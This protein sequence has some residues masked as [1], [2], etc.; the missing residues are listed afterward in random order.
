MKTIIKKAKLRSFILKNMYIFAASL[1]LAGCE[2]EAPLSDRSVVDLG[3]VKRE[4]TELD[5]WILE[6]FTLPYGIEVK[7]RWDRNVAQNG[8]YT[9]PPE[10]AN[11]KSV[12]NAIKTLWI[13]LYTSPEIGG[14]KFLLGKNPIKIYMYGGK[15]LDGNGMEL[16]DNP[17]ATSNEMFLY[18]VNEF[19]PRNEDKVFV[20]MRSVHH[21]FARHLME[22]FPYDRKKF[23]TISRNRY[24]DSTKPIAGAVG[25]MQGRRAFG[26]A[27]YANRNGFFTFHSL[28]SAEKD[29][30]E[31]ISA[32][33]THAPK[34]IL[35]ALIEAKTPYNAGPDSDLQ[36]VYNENARQA[37][38][39]LVEKQ[40][41]VE[42]YFSKEI[43]LSLNYLQLIS[44]KQMK[45][46]IKQE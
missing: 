24:L 40:A 31:I 44:I 2:K 18:N 12:L 37:Y 8:N 42:E 14:E 28:L 20:L 17:E 43:K 45:A 19:D 5:K 25:V 32:K 6:T 7:Y 21:Q 29:F 11:V 36:L 13:A 38:K 22:L 9:Y 39:E 34:E 33:L 41:F 26:L 10:T 27:I 15:N 16:L 3:A 35:T 23:L 46:F 4:Q 1:L 30:A